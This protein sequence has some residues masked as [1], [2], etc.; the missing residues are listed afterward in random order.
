LNHSKLNWIW[1]NDLCCIDIHLKL[2]A[3]DVK[4]LAFQSTLKILLEWMDEKRIYIKY[5]SSWKL[6]DILILLIIIN[7]VAH[8]ASW[9]KN[10]NNKSIQT[11]HL[12]I[13]CHLWAF[14]IFHFIFIIYVLTFPTHTIHNVIQGNVFDIES[15]LMPNYPFP[16]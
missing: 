1:S 2:M 13:P 9:K 7:F 5:I 6:V 11:L 4:F 3:K 10:N 16:I 8:N 12:K 14:F 15:G